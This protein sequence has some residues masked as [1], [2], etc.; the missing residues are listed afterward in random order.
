MFSALTL[1]FFKE[2][3]RN[4]YNLDINQPFFKRNI[5]NALKF[6]LAHADTIDTFFRDLA[7]ECLQKLKTGLIQT[8]ISTKVLEH[9]QLNENYIVA[10]DGT[11]TG[12]YGEHNSEGALKKESKNGVIAYYRAVLEAKLVTKSGFCISLGS[13]WIENVDEK[14][15]KQDCEQNAFKRLAEQLKLDY[16]TLPITLVLDALFASESVISTCKD[17][18]WNFFVVQKNNF[19]KFLVEEIVLCPG[20]QT[21]E[22]KYKKFSFLNNIEYQKDKYINWF[23]VTDESEGFKSSWI[24]NLIITKKS[25]ILFESIARLRWKIENEGFNEQKNNGY[26]LEHKYNRANLNAIKNYYQCLQIASIIDQLVFLDNKVKKIM[27]K[28]SKTK[29]IEWC[30]A[31]LIMIRFKSEEIEKQI[32][33]NFVCSYIE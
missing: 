13:V 4:A 9:G 20:K 17:N 10:I 24:S 8:L 14:Y 16:P 2:G 33:E 11:N 18:N 26:N 21:V 5:Q 30:R 3:S 1:F 6:K 7:P 29:A 28:I 19:Y 31:I 27:N 12:I 23:T 32:S 25:L 22:F 15:D